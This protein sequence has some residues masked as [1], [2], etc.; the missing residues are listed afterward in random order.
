MKY[1]DSVFAGILP[2]NMSAEFVSTGVPTG[3]KERPQFPSRG[4]DF[5]PMIPSPTWAHPAVN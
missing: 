4:I 5:W 2:G 3:I 1:E